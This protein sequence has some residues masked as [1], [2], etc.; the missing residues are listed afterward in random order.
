LRNFCVPDMRIARAWRAAADGAARAAWVPP[1]INITY[2]LITMML[3]TQ[4]GIA[5]R[6]CGP[7]RG[8]WFVRDDP[9]QEGLPCF[10][11]GAGCVF[12]I[13]LQA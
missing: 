2:T 4:E 7:A 5:A 6:R 9:T 1:A 8:T 11:I 10:L 12:R 3:D 13:L